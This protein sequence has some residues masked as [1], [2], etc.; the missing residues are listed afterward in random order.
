MTKVK[1]AMDEGYCDVMGATV[2]LPYWFMPRLP[3]SDGI[4]FLE[5]GIRWGHGAI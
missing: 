5:P 4:D 2:G 1:E 3:H